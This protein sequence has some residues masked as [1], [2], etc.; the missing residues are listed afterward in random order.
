MKTPAQVHGLGGVGGD[1]KHTRSSA[2]RTRKRKRTCSSAP[3]QHCIHACGGSGWVGK[4]TRSSAPAQHCIHARERGSAPA[5]AH[6]LSTASTHAAGGGWQ[7]HPLKCTRSA[8]HPRTRKRK[9]TCSSAPAQ[10]CIHATRGPGFSL[11]WSPRVVRTCGRLVLTFEER[12]SSRSLPSAR[13]TTHV[14]RPCGRFLAKHA[15]KP[16]T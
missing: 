9:R 10:H 8:L 5:Q 1:G 14:E 2:P 3:A 6:P 15:E 4:H 16:A 11:V 13:D 7:A 12:P